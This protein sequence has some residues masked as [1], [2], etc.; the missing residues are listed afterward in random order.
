MMAT[1]Q[2]EFAFRKKDFNHIAGL[3]H[4]QTGIKLADHKFDMMYA[5]L[6]RRLRQLGLRKVEDY[7]AFFESADGQDEL[8]NL[9]NAMTTNLTRF[10]RESHHFDT[11]RDECLASIVKKVE[12]GGSRKIRIWSAGCS[13]GMEPYTIA[14]T[15][16]MA[17]PDF[18]KWD[19][20]ILATD[21]DTGMLERGR[22]GLYKKEDLADVPA[23][24]RKKY[25]HKAS[26]GML[27]ID[28][29]LK[30]LIRFKKLNL[31]H[32]WPF[33]GPFDVIFCRNVLIYFDKETRD[34]LVSRYADMLAPGGYLFL[35]HSEALAGEKAGLKSVGRSSFRKAV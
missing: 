7:I 16:A 23:V 19:A 33:K 11:L 27:Q 35:G 29:R 17:V 10:F 32:D 6:A 5:R 8:P 30:S 18:A 15:L 24:I 14:M 4:E 34:D 31:L 9:I 13:S 12:R 1:E 25:A 28:D 21:I 2:R 3:I 20:L 22:A 26:G